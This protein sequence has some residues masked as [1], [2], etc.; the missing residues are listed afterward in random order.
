MPKRSSSKSVVARKTPARGARALSE[1][2]SSVPAPG[3]VP[4]PRLNSVSKKPKSV[5][6]RMCVSSRRVIPAGFQSTV[7]ASWARAPAPAAERP[8]S[9]EPIS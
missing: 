6:T 8:V 1:P 2:P 9:V 3:D 7:E 5:P 4:P